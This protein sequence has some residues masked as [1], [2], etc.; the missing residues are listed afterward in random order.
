MSNPTSNFINVQVWFLFGA[1]NEPYGKSGILHLL[2]HIKIAQAPF[3]DSLFTK[4]S[5]TGATSSEIIRFQ[6]TTTKE[7]LH[8]DIDAFFNSLTNP[9]IDSMVFE[10]QKRQVSNEVRYREGNSFFELIDHA[11]EA[12]F[13]NSY[14]NNI[15]GTRETI[16]NI[17]L[18]GIE[19][20]NNTVFNQSK[21]LISISGGQFINDMMNVL[22]KYDIDII[23][24]NE[25]PLLY[26]GND[27]VFAESADPTALVCY[28]APGR[29]FNYDILKIV[30]LII[31]YR[32]ITKSS[33][34]LILLS[35]FSVSI[36]A[37]YARGD[38]AQEQL[39][40]IKEDLMDVPS[41]EFVEQIVKFYLDSKDYRMHIDP[42]KDL[43]EER[44][45]QLLPAC[46]ID[47]MVQRAIMQYCD[48]F[49][50][51]PLYSVFLR[52]KGK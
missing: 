38:Y 27:I 22:D 40:K 4:S 6:F 5:F 2:E 15:G 45:Y 19:K 7:R 42:N 33:I 44:L 9:S 36:F 34:R 18:L 21:Y 47:D 37:L 14:A 1:R 49:K 8:K 16:E 35:W 50:N 32:H 52:S 39:E 29:I 23:V 20:Y 46:L 43:L 17:S 11:T 25:L 26:A 13:K 10:A 24:N 51:K 41:E 31:Q 3:K 48:I 12:I 30:E 28:S